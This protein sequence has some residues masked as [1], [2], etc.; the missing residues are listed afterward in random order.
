MTDQPWPTDWMRSILS[1][2]VLALVAE[3][4]TYGYAVA[5]RLQD[6][7]LGTVKGG[8]LYPVLT[9]LEQDGLLDSH[10]QAGDG[11]PG[12]KYYTV[13]DEGRTELRRRTDDWMTFTEQ[14]ARLLPSRTADR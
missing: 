5:Q 1:L 6:A 4:R 7:G 10:W 9:R 2:A 14:A 3:G 12:R 11:G 8:T 13:T